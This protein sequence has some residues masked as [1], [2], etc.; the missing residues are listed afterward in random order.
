MNKKVWIFIF[1][2]ITTAFV[3]AEDITSLSYGKQIVY[4]S[5]VQTID[6]NIEVPLS[7][8]LADAQS[9][10]FGFTQDE[11]VSLRTQTKSISTLPLSR[12]EEREVVSNNVI[13]S[14]SFKVY[15]KIISGYGL[16]FSLAADGPFKSK[17]NATINYSIYDIGDNIILG[18]KG[19]NSRNYIAP[20]EIGSFSPDYTNQ[21]FSEAELVSLEIVTTDDLS[22][23]FES[24][25]SYSTILKITVEVTN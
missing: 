14:A 20:V 22:A 16:K 23:A 3:F 11:S 8:S 7:F 19:N 6:I 2:F 4:D 5:E 17:E 9:Y 10:E 12:D 18:D 25:S 21:D 1:I 13:A 15:W 24:S